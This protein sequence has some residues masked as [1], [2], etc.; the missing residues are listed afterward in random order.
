MSHY[1]DGPLTFLA[2]GA[3]GKHILV[4]ISAAKTVDVCGLAEEPIGVL[5][6]AAF[7]AGDPCTV[8]PLN[9]TGS[10][11]CIAANAVAVGVPVYGRALGKVD[12]VSTSSAVRIGISKEAATAAG[13]VIEVIPDR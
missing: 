13:D 5:S 7:A 2:A 1:H 11:N 9:K 3:I 8:I 10:I 4:K 12:D 6:E